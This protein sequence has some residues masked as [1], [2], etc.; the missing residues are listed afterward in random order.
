M[1][2]AAMIM[3]GGS[4]GNRESIDNL[5]EAAVGRK[6]SIDA[7]GV[8]CR[9]EAVEK[10]S[11]YDLNLVQKIFTALER[12]YLTTHSSGVEN[13]V[14]YARLRRMRF[15]YNNQVKGMQ[16][17]ATCNIASPKMPSDHVNL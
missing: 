9:Q 5:S 14:M 12:T 10:D 2:A 7:T 1:L 4:H 15:A 13:R 16:S 8:G 11:K 6:F 3:F 17:I